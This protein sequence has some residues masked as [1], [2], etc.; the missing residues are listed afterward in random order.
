MLPDYEKP[1]KRKHKYVFHLPKA[2]KKTKLGKRLSHESF[3]KKDKATM[4]SFSDSD[5]TS[6]PESQTLSEEHISPRTPSVNTEVA[7]VPMEEKTAALNLERANDAATEEAVVPFA[8]KG[9]I[10]YAVI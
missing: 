7:V 4:L 5:L 2:F 3:N 1:S 8:D 10:K 9:I 6:N